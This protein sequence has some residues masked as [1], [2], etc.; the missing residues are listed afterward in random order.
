MSELPRTS[1]AV[2]VQKRRDPILDGT[3]RKDPTKKIWTNPKASE[4]LRQYNQKVHSRII[5]TQ[6]S[7]SGKKIN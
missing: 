5:G 7:V 3:L 1:K 2:A 6:G 4:Q